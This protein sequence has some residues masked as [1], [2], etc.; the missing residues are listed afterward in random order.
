MKVL[1]ILMR[2]DMLSMNPG[3]AIA[4]GAD[5]MR[6]FNS[7]PYAE[8]EA[9]W[10]GLIR[11]SDERQ[12]DEDRQEAAA[13]ADFRKL[14]ADTIAA[15]A[16]DGATAL[17]WLRDADEQRGD[18]LSYFLWAHGLNSSKLLQELG[19]ELGFGYRNGHLQLMQVAA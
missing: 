16:A 2:T 11:E 19:A 1:Y 6:H 4:Q 5:F 12:D 17:R 3:K 18:D 13:L 8:Q 14:I 10:D 9:I 7:L 15:G